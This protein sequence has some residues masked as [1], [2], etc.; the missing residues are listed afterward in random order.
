LLT[1]E[2]IFKKEKA[3]EIAGQL[4]GIAEGLKYGSVSATVK[5]YGGK[6][7]TVAYTKTEQT[8]EQVKKEDKAYS[9][10]C[11]TNNEYAVSERF[12]TMRLKDMGYEQS[13]NSE[14]RF[15]TGISLM[16]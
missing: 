7:V 8:M 4:L 15:W 2:V 5:F 14:A 13:K 11:D 16:V 1:A 10:C 12:F 6:L 9:D 3:E